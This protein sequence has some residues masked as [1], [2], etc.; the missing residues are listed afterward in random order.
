MF[1]VM[2]IL[3][4]ML[5]PSFFLCHCKTCT[6]LS[7]FSIFLFHVGIIR[8]SL[9]DNVKLDHCLVLCEH[10]NCTAVVVE[11]KF[12]TRWCCF[13]KSDDVIYY[14]GN[15]LMYYTKMVAISLQK[16]GKFLNMSRL[17]Q[18]FRSTPYVFINDYTSA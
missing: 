17:T 11:T 8:S 4:Y 3:V 18:L 5:A 9:S 14:H 13:V 16:E 10:Q 6:N 12:T 2:G 7:Q 1:F 15:N